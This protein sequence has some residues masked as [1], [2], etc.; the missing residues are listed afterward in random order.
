MTVT[1]SSNVLLPYAAHVPG[2][3]VP[4]SLNAISG[5]A[6]SVTSTIAFAEQSDSFSDAGT[7]SSVYFLYTPPSSGVLALFTDGSTFDASVVVYAAMKVGSKW[8]ADVSA[9]LARQESS[10]AAAGHVS[11][12]CGCTTVAVAAGKPLAIAVRRD[13][14]SGAA[15]LTAQNCTATL[16]WTLG[17]TTLRMCGMG[18]SVSKYL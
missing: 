12:T 2:N 10:C 1:H 5:A 16:S 8:V 7:S 15:M 3:I 6:G 14:E 9:S 17:G 4:T 18:A 11:D 13:T